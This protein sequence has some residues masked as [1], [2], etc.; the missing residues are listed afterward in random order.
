MA[1]NPLAVYLDDVA[2]FVR[3]PAE[4]TALPS[5][6]G[7]MV[8]AYRTR[9]GLSQ[10][11]LARSAGCDPAYINRLERAS[12]SATALPSRRIVLGIWAALANAAEGTA[13]PITADDRERLLVAAGYCPET[14]LAAGGWDQFVTTIRRR[15]IVG[16]AATIEQL[17]ESL[18]TVDP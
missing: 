8:A 12:A 13:Y 3:V 5:T 6:L 7:A 1:A 18:S 10:N 11:K 2:D 14:I 4:I 16:L 9:Y 15:V 17:D